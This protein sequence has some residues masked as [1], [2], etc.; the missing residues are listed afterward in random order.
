[1]APLATFDAAAYSRA[2]FGDLTTISAVAIQMAWKACPMANAE[3]W[4]AK[5]R[6]SKTVAD[7]IGRNV[8][9]GIMRAQREDA[10]RAFAA[11]LT[12]R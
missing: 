2:L 8:L 7:M 4:L 3:A 10:Q 12:I 11:A 5:F 6:S 9:R 1:M